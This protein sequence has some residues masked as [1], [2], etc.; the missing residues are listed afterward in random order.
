MVASKI[1]TN[2]FHPAVKEKSKLRM[3]LSGPSGSG[4]TWSA[5]L[6]A[7]KIAEL[8]GGKIALIDTEGRSASKYAG[9]FTF[10]VLDLSGDYDP[11]RYITG[12]KAAVQF[13]YTI[14]VID[15]FTHAWKGAGGVLEIVDKAGAKMG[16]NDWAGWSKGRPAHNAFIDSIINSQVHIIGTARSKTLWELVTNDRGK[17]EPTKIGMG[18]DQSADFEYEFDVA[19]QIDMAH[20]MHITKTRCP[21][22]DTD[23]AID[24]TDYVAQTLHAWLT[25][26]APPTVPLSIMEARAKKFVNEARKTYDLTVD[27]LKT[28]LG[29]VDGFGEF[30][31]SQADAKAQAEKLVEAYILQTTPPATSTPKDDPRPPAT[32][33]PEPDDAP[34][35][36]TDDEFTDL[37]LQAADEDISQKDLLK[38][39]AVESRADWTQGIEAAKAKLVAHIAEKNNKGKGKTQ[40]DAATD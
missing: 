7:S 33:G 25:D 39:L 30:D 1:E 15:S 31:W 29:V 6:I 24:D 10:D 34:S 12:I 37:A 18:A 3:L 36:L 9:T 20:K 22:L 5:L 4:K 2:P 27:A 35:G 11:Q 40:D 19:A 23:T 21:I 32:P 8:E 28:A 16:G 13:G 26:G 38:V 17:Q 14:L